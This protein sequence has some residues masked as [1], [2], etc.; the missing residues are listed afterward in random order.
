[1]RHGITHS[2]VEEIDPRDIENYK[3][4]HTVQPNKFKI[5][6]QPQMDIPVEQQNQKYQ[7]FDMAKL[8]H[9]RKRI[10]QRMMIM[11]LMIRLKVAETLNQIEPK[12]CVRDELKFGIAANQGY[13]INLRPYFAEKTRG[14]CF[15]TIWNEMTLCSDKTVKEYVDF[16]T[17][18]LKV[19]IKSKAYIKSA[20]KFI[21]SIMTESEAPDYL[22]GY[23]FSNPG[24]YV[25]KGFTFQIDV[26]EPFAK[27]GLD[28][29][30]N[31]FCNNDDVVVNTRYSGM[32]NAIIDKIFSWNKALLE[33]ITDDMTIGKLWDLLQ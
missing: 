25:T 26:I 3:F 6:R 29:Q 27:Y 15:S 10:S 31:Y 17:Q 30:Q 32:Y 33:N 28:F 5:L 4:Q 23:F 12:I 11:N 19:Q 9:L 7:H 2:Y 24:R 20:K 21:D 8:P 13:V 16:L 22:V 18:D 14:S 1:M